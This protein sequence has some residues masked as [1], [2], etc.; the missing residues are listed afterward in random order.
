VMNT[1][2]STS[3]IWLRREFTLKPEDLSGIQLQIFHDEDVEVYL[4]GVPAAKLS[5]YIT[6]YN[7][8]EI[9][10][11]AAAALHPG[12]N[13]IAVHCHQTTGGQG[14]DVGIFALQTAREPD[15]NEK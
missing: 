4:N 6:D 7:E 10:T 2:W 3:D 15:H 14:V 5:G 1:A 12:E 11:E 8:F 9:S 13:T